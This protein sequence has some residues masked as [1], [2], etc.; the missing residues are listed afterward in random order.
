MIGLGYVGLPLAEEF[1][2][3]RTVVSFE[4]N[5]ARIAELRAGEDN[6]LEVDA[7][8]LAKAKH[9]FSQKTS[10]ILLIARD[11]RNTRVIDIIHELETYGIV[12]DVYDP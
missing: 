4:I 11:L 6:T 10:V 5:A 2:K 3:Q 8:E 1:G 12:V 7:T 9:L